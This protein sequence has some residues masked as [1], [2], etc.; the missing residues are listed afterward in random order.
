[1]VSSSQTLEGNE[2]T[3]LENILPDLKHGSEASDQ[4]DFS[5]TGS[6]KSDDT[7]LLENSQSVSLPSISTHYDPTW[8]RKVHAYVASTREEVLGDDDFNQN[9]KQAIQAIKAGVQPLRIRAG[10]SYFVR[11]INQQNI[12]VFKPKDEEPFAPQNPKW[13]KYFQRMLC[14]CCFG[15]ACLIPNNG[16]LSETGA[17][18][19]DEKLQLHIV[20]KTRVVKLASPAFYYRRRS[21]RM[22]KELKGKDGSY[23][24]YVNGYVSASQIVP[25]WSKEG[26]ACPLTESEMERFKYLFQKLC[27]L[28][29]I[30]RNTDRHMD[31]WL[32][33]YE[34][35][36]VLELAAIDNGL[37]FPVKHP[38]TAS[39]LRQFPFA[40][41][42]L[43]WANHV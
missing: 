24:M 20:P 39:R 41:A 38:E 10:R 5:H 40:W 30:I 12:A 37:A 33:K 2:E 42:Q 11:D 29:Y 19:V 6:L 43:S 27:V 36:Q 14:F 18:L 9:L 25:Q 28:D 22:S 15:R 4:L 35:G 32:I 26:A 17:S 1:M 34:P 16:Y 21:R 8:L 13:P 3:K 31:N 7:C 23:Q